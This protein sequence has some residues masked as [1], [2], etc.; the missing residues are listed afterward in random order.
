MTANQTAMVEGF[1]RLGVDAVACY[2]GKYD[3]YRRNLLA[4]QERPA[5][6]HEYFVSSLA[7]AKR[8]IPDY[9]QRA[10][11]VPGYWGWMV[12]K[13]TLDCIIH[14]RTWYLITEGSSGSPYT[15]I[16]RKL[17]AWAA[18]RWA[19]QVLC[20]GEKACREFEALGVEKTK[21]TWTAYATPEVPP[22]V[23]SA[24][25]SSE[26]C[27]FVYVGA[28]TERKACD[29]L[30]AAWKRVHE[31]VKKTRL[32]VVGEGPLKPLFTGLDGVELRG[33]VPPERVYAEIAGGD[34]IIL[35]SR[36]DPWGVAL[37]EGAM[38]G[39]AM[40]GSDAVN[41]A[42]LIE[43]G[44]NGRRVRAGDL[45]DLVRAMREYALNPAA[46]RHQGAAAHRTA[47]KTTGTALANGKWKMENE[48]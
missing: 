39:M 47:L 12:W 31:E 11:V 35:V 36:Y 46:A 26:E 37:M 34:V 25:R 4:W 9:D 29:L 17:M 3:E 38:C 6:E 21:I 2:F 7:E 14:R 48:S 10:Q 16:L 43:D 8:R 19:K 32:L 41:S 40:I 42:E 5:G 30:A 33:A 24:E 20:I 23:V 15:W 13:L 22:E 28:L 18:N 1:R 44:I 27:V 45:E